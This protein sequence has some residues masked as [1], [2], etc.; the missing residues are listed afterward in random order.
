MNR[1]TFSFGLAAATLFGRPLTARALTPVAQPIATLPQVQP[2]A[3]PADPTAYIGAM[4]GYPDAPAR[5]LIYSDSQCQ[6]CQQF[7]RD[8]L[9]SL[10]R[11]YIEP[12]KMLLEYREHPIGG[13]GGLAAVVNTSSFEAQALL[14]AGEQ[15]AYFEMLNAQMQR[16]LVYSSDVIDAMRRLADGIGIDADALATRLEDRYYEPVLHEAVQ[17]GRCRGVTAT[18][19]FQIGPIDDRAS[20]LDAELLV[21]PL[22]GYDVFREDIDAA[23]AEIG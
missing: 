9:P 15:D 2:V 1:R 17:D 21:L 3:D 6:Y 8:W 13:R 5:M 14:A 19:T 20:V 11:D 18:P 22:A 23:L 16:S 7:Y 12:G 10:L 4:L